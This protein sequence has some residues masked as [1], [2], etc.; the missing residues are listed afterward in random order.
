VATLIL[1]LV[2]RRPLTGMLDRVQHL[3]WGDKEADLEGLAEAAQGVQKALEEAARPLPLDRE[4]AEKERKT[5]IER[6]MQNAVAW[7]THMGRAAEAAEVAAPKPKVLWEGME[8]TLMADLSHVE[9]QIRK[10]LRHRER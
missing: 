1:G 6:L 5:R 9:L 4:E 10:R 8:P 7:G 3:K 2:L